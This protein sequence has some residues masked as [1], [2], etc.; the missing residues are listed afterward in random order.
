MSLSGQLGNNL[1]ISPSLMNSA[2]KLR[3][4]VEQFVKL[5]QPEVGY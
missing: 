5:M 2:G 1:S 3:I 4:F